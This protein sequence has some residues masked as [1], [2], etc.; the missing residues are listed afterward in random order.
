MGDKE[1]QAGV[2][3]RVAVFSTCAPSRPMPMTLPAYAADM[4]DS[5]RPIMRYSGRPADTCEMFVLPAAPGWLGSYRG[6]ITNTGE[7]AGSGCGGAHVCV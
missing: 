4:G 2:E 1:A 7:S 6:P 5:S 3:H